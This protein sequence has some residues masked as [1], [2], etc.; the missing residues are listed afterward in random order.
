MEKQTRGGSQPEKKKKFNIIDDILWILLIF[1]CSYLLFDHL[2]TKPDV[3]LTESAGPA[4][5]S[6]A[7]AAKDLGEYRLNQALQAIKNSQEVT[8]D[9]PIDIAWEGNIMAS[10]A[11][12]SDYGVKTI[13]EDPDFPYFYVYTG[14]GEDLALDGRIKVY[15]QWT[16]VTCAYKNSMFG[17]CTAEVS[18]TRVTQTKAVEND[19]WTSAEK[20]YHSKAQLCQFMDPGP[21]DPKL[22]KEYSVYFTSPEI[23]H[24]RK[25][26]NRFL[27]GSCQDASCYNNHLQAYGD[28]K[29]IDREYLKSKFIVID[30]N[31]A[32]YGGKD[33]TIL[34]EDKPD[35]LFKAVVYDYRDGT[36]DL[37]DVS[38]YDAPR[39][40]TFAIRKIQLYLASEICS[41]KFGI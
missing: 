13:P 34:F 23:K 36:Y 41:G 32:L 4:S 31:T 21:P 3:I 11:S 18:A 14:S 6:E 2:A 27:D 22:V 17:Q 26:L 29:N 40:S 7:S 39:D 10:F 5:G 1:V 28:L 9:D 30:A 12:G 19:L 20:I 24:F 33:L 38:E 25:S 16:G 15:G 35:Q 37:R 8:F